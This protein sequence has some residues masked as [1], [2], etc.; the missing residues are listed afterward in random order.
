MENDKIQVANQD[1]RAIPVQS[2]PGNQGN[3]TEYRDAETPR[4]GGSNLP[5]ALSDTMG[6]EMELEGVPEDSAA[7]AWGV[8]RVNHLRPIREKNLKKNEDW[9]RKSRVIYLTKSGVK[10]IS[11]KIGEDPER[12][13][14]SA[15]NYEKKIVE[16]M[17][18]VSWPKHGNTWHFINKRLIRCRRGNG[19]EVMVTVRDSRNYRPTLQSGKPMEIEAVLEGERWTHIGRDPRRIGRW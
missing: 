5:R 14:E 8:S 4:G 13:W 15:K 2:D 7:D 9:F 10:K 12:L 17:A 6:S 3:S 18:V 11:E 16:K 1:R 19:Q